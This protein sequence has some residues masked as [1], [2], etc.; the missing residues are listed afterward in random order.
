MTI[1]YQI[2][3]KCYIDFKDKNIACGIN[4]KEFKDVSNLKVCM[5]CHIEKERDELLV[6]ITEGPMFG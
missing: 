5:S 4:V 6:S 3:M 2:K 1:L